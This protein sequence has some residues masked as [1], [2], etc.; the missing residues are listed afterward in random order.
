MALKLIQAEETREICDKD[1]PGIADGD[2]EVFYTIRS[3]DQKTHRKLVKQN[4]KQVF[5]RG[6]GRVDRIDHPAAADDIIDYVLV[7]WRGILLG[8]SAA[9]CTRENKLCLDFARRSAL[10]DLAG[11]NEIA[12]GQEARVESFRATAPGV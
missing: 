10:N 4:T 3:L 8:G 9:P 11:M 6:V 2:A 5:E 1:L 12:R 7:G